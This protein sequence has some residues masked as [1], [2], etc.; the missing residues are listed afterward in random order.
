MCLNVNF[1]PHYFMPLMAIPRGKILLEDEKDY[2]HRDK[3]ERNHHRDQVP[4]RWHPV[5]AVTGGQ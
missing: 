3:L 4:R 2:K 5:G 1:L